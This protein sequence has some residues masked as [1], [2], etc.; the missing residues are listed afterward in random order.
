MT[1]DINL[2]IEWYL[3]KKQF[4]VEPFLSEFVLF[5][6]KNAIFTPFLVVFPM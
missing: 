6:L 2:Y 5:F 3:M 1:F 4:F